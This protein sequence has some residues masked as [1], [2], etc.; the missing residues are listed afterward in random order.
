MQSISEQ[1]ENHKHT[2]LHVHIEIKVNTFF[3]ESA[4]SML[5]ELEQV[6]KASIHV[7]FIVKPCGWPWCQR[8]KI[9]LA[10]LADC[11]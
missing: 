11:V 5:H 2:Y 8:L 1:R 9:R 4:K 7:H 10:V 3:N 6:Y